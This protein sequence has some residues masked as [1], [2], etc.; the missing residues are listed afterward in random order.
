[1]NYEHPEIRNSFI[2]IHMAKNYL[3]LMRRLSKFCFKENQVRSCKQYI[4]ELLK[5]I[6]E[7]RTGESF[8]ALAAADDLLMNCESAIRAY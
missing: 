7:M 6:S 4:S 5:L 3:S 1:M 8:E 2:T